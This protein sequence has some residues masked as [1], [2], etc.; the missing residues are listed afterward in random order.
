MGP[1]ASLSEGGKCTCR[2]FPA[3]TQS[4]SLDKCL[5]CQKDTS[6]CGF[7]GLSVKFSCGKIIGFTASALTE[8]LFW[9]VSVCL[10]DLKHTKPVLAPPSRAMLKVAHRPGAGSAG[11][12][13][14]A[15]SQPEGTG[16]RQ[17]WEG[18]SS[19]SWQSGPR[20]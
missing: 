19:A 16:D 3:T 2:E 4:W 12:T 13:A 17:R 5:S 10:L 18:W 11:W 15:G 14:C 8:R 20:C 7:G 6:S 1:A 9:P